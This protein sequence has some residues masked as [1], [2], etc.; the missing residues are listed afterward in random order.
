MKNLKSK[1]ESLLFISNQPLALKKLADL[2]KTETKEVS[3]AIKELSV[4]YDQRQGGVIFQRIGDKVQLASSP[5]NAKLVKDYIKEETTGELSRASLE[6]LTIIAYRGP[7]TKAELEQIRGV[8]CSVILRNL[9]I[10]GLVESKASSA[11]MQNTYNITFD[12][13]KFLGLSHQSDLPDYE[14]LNSH[15]SIQKV[16]GSTGGQNQE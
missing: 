15:E 14:K 9:L 8:N 3:E 6:T 12:F 5:D 16:L 4:E 1:I 13:L 2:T 11:K 7:I 10:R